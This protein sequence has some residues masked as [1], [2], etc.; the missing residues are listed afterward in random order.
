MKHC[1]IVTPGTI[2]GPGCISSG[3]LDGAG[4]PAVYTVLRT[5]PAGR[6]TPTHR[7]QVQ[8]MQLQVGGSGNHANMLTNRLCH[9]TIG[10]LSTTVLL[11]ASTSITVI[12]QAV[13]C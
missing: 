1:L 5:C 8:P 4:Q 2:A 6:P 7:F 10:A 13:P 3:E 12:R 9:T 11:G